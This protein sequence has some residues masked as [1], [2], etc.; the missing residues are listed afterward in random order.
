MAFFK[1]AS[2]KIAKPKILPSGWN[3][4]KTRVAK[5]STL[6]FKKVLAD[7]HPDKY[8]LTHCTIISSVDTEDA[9][10]KNKKGRKD[11]YITPDTSKFVNDNGDAWERELLKKSYKTFI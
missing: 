1:T 8:L 10:K 4:F 6:D 7:Y 11:Y 3:D 5:S 9:P 2:A